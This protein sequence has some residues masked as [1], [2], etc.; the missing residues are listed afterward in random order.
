MEKMEAVRFWWSY[1]DVLLRRGDKWQR[2]MRLSVCQCHLPA[3]KT[4]CARLNSFFWLDSF[5]KCQNQKWSCVCRGLGRGNSTLDKANISSWRRI[6]TQV[7]FLFSSSLWVQYFSPMHTSFVWKP[8]GV[9]KLYYSWRFCCKNN[10]IIS[11]F[12]RVTPT[13]KKI[14]LS[15]I[16]T[17]K[18]ME[19]VPTWLYHQST[20]IFTRKFQQKL[21]K[22]QRGNNLTTNYVITS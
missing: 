5:G 8:E 11:V 22:L 20:V 18:Q 10:R 17:W 14:I 1:L 16:E 9:I 15:V 3:F 12:L 2:N 7:K 6:R 13:H 19:L 4:G 21:K